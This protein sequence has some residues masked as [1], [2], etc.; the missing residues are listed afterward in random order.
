[1]KSDVMQS[2][3]RM[4]PRVLRQLVKEVKETVATDVDFGKTNKGAFSIV[5]LWNIRRNRRTTGSRQ[6]KTT[7]ITGIGY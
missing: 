5:N 7:I 3:V 4:E 2:I 6:K 1:M